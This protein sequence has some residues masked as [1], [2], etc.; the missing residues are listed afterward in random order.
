MFGVQ[1][2]G[3]FMYLCHDI[4]ILCNVPAINVYIFDQYG[5]KIIFN[6]VCSGTGLPFIPGFAA[7]PGPGRKQSVAELPTYTSYAVSM[8]VKAW[9]AC[10]R[11]ATSRGSPPFGLAS[12][13]L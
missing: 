4:I 13:S 11:M 9:S 5:E 3:N 8:L 10:C 12:I 2:P 6:R 7:L 1:N